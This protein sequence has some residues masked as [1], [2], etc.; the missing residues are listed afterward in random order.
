[1]NAQVVRIIIFAGISAAVIAI[2]PLPPNASRALAAGE[3]LFAGNAAL[4]FFV[5]RKIF[6][7]GPFENRRGGVLFFLAFFLKVFGLGIGIYLGLVVWRLPVIYFVSGAVAGLVGLVLAVLRG[8]ATVD[9]KVDEV[10]L[11]E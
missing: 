6:N 2:L 11:A 10:S 9:K 1:M 5:A 3:L 7:A 8:S 4:L